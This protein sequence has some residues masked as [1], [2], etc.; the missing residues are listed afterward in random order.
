MI[1]E[2]NSME[3]LVEWVYKDVLTMRDY[4]LYFWDCAI[5]APRNLEVDAI[6][7]TTLSV[8]LGEETKC[9]SVDLVYGSGT[10]S[11]L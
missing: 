6:N 10:Y 11:F 4:A 2:R 8:M 9:L 5:L 1:L 3:G 7:V